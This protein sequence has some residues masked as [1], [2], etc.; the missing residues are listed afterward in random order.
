MPEPPD[1]LAQRLVNQGLAGSGLR[2]PREVASWFGAIQAQDFQGAK[3]AIGLRTKALTD[4]AVERAFDEGLI[5]RTHVLRPTWHFVAAADI[6]W[7]LALTGPR[8]IA[9]MSSYYRLLE[10]DDALVRRSRAL[11]TRALSGG[12]LTRRQIGSE[13]ERAGLTL[14]PVRLTHVIMLAELEAIVCSGPRRDR[15][16]T[17]AL[18]DDRAPRAAPVRR[19]EALARLAVRYFQSH[20]PA[21]VADFAWWS[22]LSM[23]EA[24]AAVDMAGLKMASNA[25]V[26]ANGQARPRLRKATRPSAWLLPNFDEYLVAYK[27]RQA[28]LGRHAADLR[29]SLSHTVIV[30][31]LGVATWRVQRKDA[32]ASITLVPRGRLS[33]D[34]LERI[35]HAAARYGEFIGRPVSVRS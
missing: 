20:G 18:M 10:L 15:Q 21:T 26:S 6:R 34:H 8:I 1:L 4:A 35:R 2:G 14:T 9:R 27:D 22:G 13:L 32:S 33:A 17:Y 28:I 7:L 31:G 30:D 24:R 16:C 19:D 12:F 23:R 25:L 29:D 5:L 3:W 11:L